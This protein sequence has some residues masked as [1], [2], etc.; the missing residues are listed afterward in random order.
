MIVRGKATVNQTEDMFQLIHAG[1]TDAKLDSQ[2]RALEILKAS[3]AGMQGSL[4]S[5]G[6][7]YAETRLFAQRSLSGYISEVTGGIT[8]YQGLPAMLESAEKDWPPML[9][10]LERMRTNL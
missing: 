6:N 9:A 3:K 4:R 8:Y 2:A 7:S 1:L 10:R 5:H